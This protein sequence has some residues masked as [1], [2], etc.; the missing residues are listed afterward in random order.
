MGYPPVI[1]IFLANGGYLQ[2][3]DTSKWDT[4]Q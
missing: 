3:V 4:L 2:M 1:E